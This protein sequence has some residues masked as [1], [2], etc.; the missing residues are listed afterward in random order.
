ME[1]VAAIAYIPCIPKGPL[2]QFP[3]TRRVT[4]NAAGSL[5]DSLRPTNWLISSRHLHAFRC[6]ISASL[7][8]HH[9]SAFYDPGKVSSIT[10]RVEPHILIIN[11]F[12]HLREPLDAAN[13]K[14]SRVLHCGKSGGR[15]SLANEII[16]LIT[17]LRGSVVLKLRVQS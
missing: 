16:C 17:V 9:R 14:S 13:K 3:S 5:C 12:Q 15:T 1:K 11:T 2:C 6:S 7:R 4:R 10:P 8:R